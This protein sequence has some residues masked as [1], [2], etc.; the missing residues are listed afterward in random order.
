MSFQASG[1]MAVVCALTMVA[2]GGSGES[3]TAGEDAAGQKQESAGEQPE[4]N[5]VEIGMTEYAF[6]M[7]ETITG[8]AVTLDFTNYLVQDFE[9]KLEV[10]FEVP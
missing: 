2:C 6:G 9:N 7:P 5:R 3:G 1:V 10:E 8:G 4:E